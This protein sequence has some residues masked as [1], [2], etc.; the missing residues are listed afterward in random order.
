VASIFDS[1]GTGA[2]NFDVA[3]GVTSTQRQTVA[4]D[5]GIPITTDAGTGDDGIF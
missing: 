2:F 5:F 3:S 1:A 4:F